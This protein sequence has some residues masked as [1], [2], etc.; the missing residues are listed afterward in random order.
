MD[1]MVDLTPNPATVTPA[2][3]SMTR[4]Q[5]VPISFVAAD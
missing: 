4:F 3:S 5:L 2:M 1:W